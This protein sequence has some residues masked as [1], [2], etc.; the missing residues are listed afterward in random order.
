VALA[1]Q[2]ALFASGPGPSP[3][4]LRE[5]QSQLMR[6]PTLQFSFAR[7]LPPPQVTLPHW[8]QVLDSWLGQIFGAIGHVLG[9]IFVGGLVVALLIVLFFLLREFAQT[10]W[11]NLF[12]RKQPKPAKPADWRPEAAVARALL[13]EADQ[14]AAA[15]AYAEAVRLILHRSIEEIDGRRPRLVK[16][17]LTSREIGR[18]PDIPEAA[19]TTFAAIAGVVE[20]SFFGGRA[21]DAAAFATCRRAYE[22]FAFPGAWA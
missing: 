22:A 12:K 14:L 16:P 13:D 10:R 20:H 1:A 19:R 8:L 6:D 7:A 5:A 21:I 11:P 15:G 18:L 2:P 4:A 3:A 17:A 9:W